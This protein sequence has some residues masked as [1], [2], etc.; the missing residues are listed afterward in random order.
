MASLT[1]VSLWS[2]S[3]GTD[4]S[5]ATCAF[6]GGFFLNH[7]NVPTTDANVRSS[8]EL[9]GAQEARAS[10]TDSGTL[11][12]HCHGTAGIFPSPKTICS[13]SS[14]ACEL[15]FPGRLSLPEAEGKGGAA[16]LGTPSSRRA[17]CEALS[18]LRVRTPV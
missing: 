12:S 2:T 7:T 9:D 15:V 10:I 17:M 4:I 13:F 11:E 1:K 6:C 8:A 18:V 5:V 16:G 14:Y 3:S